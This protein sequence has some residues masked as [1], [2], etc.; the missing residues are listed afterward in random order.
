MEYFREPDA[1]LGFPLAF[2]SV[3]N[4]LEFSVFNFTTGQVLSFIMV[5]LGVACFIGFY[6]FD[7]RSQARLEE[8]VIST[9]KSRKVRRRLR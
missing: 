2:T 7:K 9:N 6:V 1:G 5:G 8:L 4:P 3:N